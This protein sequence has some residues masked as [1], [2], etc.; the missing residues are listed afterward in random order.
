[1]TFDADLLDLALLAAGMLA[2]GTIGGILAGLLG[3]GGGIVV[4]PV[5]FLVLTVVGVEEEIRMHVAVATSLA[6]I[7]PTSISSF[8]SHDRKGSLDW[9]L[10]KRWAA[11]IVVGAIAGGVVAAY[12]ESGGLSL[13]FAVIA[14]LVSLFLLVRKEG[15]YI[16]PEVPRGLGGQIMPFSIGGFSTLMGIGGGTLS[17]PLLS[18]CNFPVRRAVGTAAFFGLLIAVPGT[19]AFVIS[20][21]ND[22]DLPPLSLGYVNLLGF[23]LIAP[24]QALAAP[25]GARIAHSIPPAVL[26]RLF[27]LFLFIT[28]VKMFGS[29]FELF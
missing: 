26:R 6:T 10:V 1:M 4:V 14:L 15:T 29:A 28:S 3:V 17:V 23:L 19:I 5:L 25:L 11:T 9:A 8:R 16:L 12:L 20:G 22:G 18:A 2:T 27:S 21:W 24:L 7:I 13:V